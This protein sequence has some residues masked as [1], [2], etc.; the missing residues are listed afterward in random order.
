MTLL[1]FDANDLFQRIGSTGRIP[2]KQFLSQYRPLIDE[3]RKVIP[4]HPCLVVLTKMDKL[5][6]FMDTQDGTLDDAKAQVR[7][8]VK[9]VFPDSASI[10]FI[11][12]Y[13]IP[14]K[15]DKKAFADLESGATTTGRIREDYDAQIDEWAKRNKEHLDLM[16]LATNAVRD[17]KEKLQANA[18]NTCGSHVSQATKEYCIFM[19]F[20]CFDENVPQMWHHVASCL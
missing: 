1:V 4:E 13:T 11:T 18:K 16:F 8:E 5:N 12:N 3:I 6:S 10:R 20:L 7:K 2:A 19:L 14:T 17:I 9:A 15:A